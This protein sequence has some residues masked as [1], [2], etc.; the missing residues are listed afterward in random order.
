MIA[1]LF[2]LVAAELSADQINNLKNRGVKKFIEVDFGDA[3]EHNTESLVELRQH[4]EMGGKKGK[5]GFARPQWSKRYEQDSGTKA[6]WKMCPTG[7]SYVGVQDPTY[8]LKLDKALDE[9]V[10]NKFTINRDP[11]TFKMLSKGGKATKFAELYN[12]AI[13]APPCSADGSCSHADVEFVL[14]EPEQ[15]KA[16]SDPFAGDDTTIFKEPKDSKKWLH[17]EEMKMWPQ[18]AGN[19]NLFQ[20]TTFAEPSCI[21]AGV[22]QDSVFCGLICIH[23][24]C[25]A[26]NEER[27]HGVDGEQWGSCCPVGSTCQLLAGREI[28]EDQ[29]GENGD[30]GFAKLSE[31]NAQVEPVDVGVCMYRQSSWGSKAQSASGQH[32]RPQASRNPYKMKGIHLKREQALTS[33]MESRGTHML[34][35]RGHTNAI[36]TSLETFDQ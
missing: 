19:D 35:P 17:P 5:A 11:K 1:I 7:T 3:E 16:A 22:A 4:I 25:S 21:F 24:E 14:D 26:D 27:P 9:A 20:K 34:Q 33:Y 13:C 12:Y 30:K 8:K 29:S 10:K 32:R 18:G 6:S 36:K 31:H 15:T 2:T 23:S 28:T